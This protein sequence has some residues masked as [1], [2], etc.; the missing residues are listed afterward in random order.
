MPA[1]RPLL[2][3]A[4]PSAPKYWMWETGGELAPAVFPCAFCGAPDSRQRDHAQGC[5]RLPS[6]SR[7]RLLAIAL[8]A[9]AG[10][11]RRSESRRMSV[12]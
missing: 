11:A 10:W 1:A 3:P 2:D 6:L 8:E 7:E 9:E 4:H 5:P 12:K